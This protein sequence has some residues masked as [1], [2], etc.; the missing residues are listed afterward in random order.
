MQKNE[1]VLGDSTWCP[2]WVSPAISVW[3]AG[4]KTVASYIWECT[5]F[6]CTLPYP[7]SL[8]KI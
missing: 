1:G 2:A 5:L 4:V 7:P 8:E 6:V 3:D